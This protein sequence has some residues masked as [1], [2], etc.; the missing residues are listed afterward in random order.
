MFIF[1]F[2]YLIY[3]FYKSRN[4][5]YMLQQNLYNENNRYLK[6]IKRNKEKCFNVID[7][8]PFLFIIFLFLNKDSFTMEMVYICA[9]FLYVIGIYEEYKKN[10][11]KQNKIK[12]N[13]TKRIKR[14]YITEFIIIGL[15]ITF[16]IISN[17]SGIF[18]LLINLTIALNY[19][20][21]YLVKLIN[22]PVEKLVYN[23][24]FRKAKTKLSDM[25]RLKV[26]GITGSYGKT[27]SKNILNHV[28]SSKYIT[29]PTPKNLNTPYGL[30]ITINNYLDRFDE[31]LIAEMGAYVNGEIKEICD[32][33]SPKYGIITVIGEA[34]LE[35]FKTR[36]NICQTKFE[37]IESLPEDGACVLNLDDPYQVNYVNNS[38][39]NKVKILWIGINNSEALFNAINIKCDRKG[40]NF[41]IVYL[42]NKYHVET[43]LL[44]L[45]NVYNIL[46]SFALGVELKVPIQDML[47]KIKSLAPI[48]H[49]LEIKK[50]NN[51]TMIDDAYNSN[52]IGA[53]NALDVLDMM[54]GLKVVVTPGMVELGKKE[55]ALNYEF[56]KQI[57]LVADK[58]ILVGEEKT[59]AI[60]K[61][62]LDSNYNEENILILNRVV[63]AYKELEKLVGEKEVFALFENDLPD[64]YNEGGMKK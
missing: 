9:T 58:V 11:S 21:L 44:G 22:T 8:L 1:I 63:D 35:T 55:D 16:L 53:K 46:A 30:M 12:F 41:D 20:F 52:P 7:F 29:R 23:Y 18:L 56:G 31:V 45:H 42:D 26:I 61:G 37:L 24:Y 43:K 6:W 17:F 64:I 14:L 25:N 32:F 36:D 2:I 34:H 40:T 39:K 27:S 54:K 28:L 51:I 60:K 49:R 13:I 57:S 62:L 33:V 50:L 3:V 19:Y 38:L 15:L 59:K 5:L 47:V 48:E 10:L 4:S